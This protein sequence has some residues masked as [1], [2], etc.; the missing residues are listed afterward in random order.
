VR[1]RA[2]AW[3]DERPGFRRA[4]LFQSFEAPGYSFTLGVVHLKSKRCDGQPEIISGEGCGAPVRAEEA[5]LLV[6]GAQA[7]AASE[8]LEPLLLL[9]DFNG[10]SLEAPLL[11]LRDAGFVDLLDRLPAAARYSYVFEGRASLLDHALA[12][13]GAARLARGAAIWH[14]NAD[15]PFFRGYSL[16]NPSAEYHPD[17]RRSSDHDPIIVDLGL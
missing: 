2:E 16:D 12:R 9:G 4:P 6:E 11:A 8:P 13:S 3:F 5:A 1:S 14:I 7:L 10:D 17:A 15:E